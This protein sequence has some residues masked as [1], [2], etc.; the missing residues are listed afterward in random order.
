M[1]IEDIKL[2]NID[3]LLIFDGVCKLCNGLV[4]FIIKHDRHSRIS[5]T[6]YQSEVVNR[7]QEQYDLKVSPSDTIIYIDKGTPLYKSTALIRILKDLGGLWMS[8]CI[9]IAIPRAIR[10]WLYDRIAKNRYKI[11]G[12]KDYCTI[13]SDELKDR[14][15]Q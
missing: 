3:K 11:F 12:K 8:V 7:I 5:F 6:Y 4:Y 9:L 15:L 13:P 1:D 2:K 14:F 10:D